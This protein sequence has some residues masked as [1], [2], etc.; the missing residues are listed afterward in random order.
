MDGSKRQGNLL[1]NCLLSV[2]LVG[3]A[4]SIL[5]QDQTISQMVHTVWTGRD[6]A[7]AGI[8]SLAQTPD[9]ILWIA[10]LKGLYS[11]DGLSFA[12][13]EPAPGSASLTA[14]TLRLLFVAKS[15]ELWVAGYHG[16]AIQIHNGRV[17][18]YSRGD[19][20]IDALDYLQQDPSGAMWAVAND[21]Q[22]IRLGA[23]EI[24]HSMPGPIQGQGHISCLFIDSMGTQWVIQNNILY[25]KP[26]RLLQFLPTGVSAHFQPTIREGAHHTVWVMAPT[27]RTKRGDAEPP[28]LQQV[29][30]SGRRLVGPRNVGDLN[31]ILPA[32]DG[33][34]W[35][36][37]QNDELRHLRRWEISEPNSERK[38]HIA[39]VAKLSRGAT[40][41]EFH[42]FMFDADGD[43]WVGGLDGLERFARATLVPAV[44]GAPPGFWHSCVGPSGDIFISRLPAELYRIRNEKLTRIDGVKGGGNLFCSQG[45]IFYLDANGIANL[46]DGKQ[47]HLPLLPG[48][49]GYGDH[50]VFTGVLPMPDGS[51]IGAVG[52][53]PYGTSLWVYKSGKWSRFL[54]NETFPET[55]AMFVDSQGTIYLGHTNGD[56]NRVSGNVFTALHKGSAQFNGVLGFAQTSHG[57]FA[58]GPRG[59]GL[60]RQSSLQLIK[61]RDLDYSKGVTGL[62]EEQNGDV[63]INGFD[64]VVRIPSAEIRAALSDPDYRVSATNLQEQD[65]KGPGLPLLFSSTAHVGPSGRLWFS[66]LNGVVSVD[67]R[68]LGSPHPPLLSIRSITA[69]GSALNAQNEFPPNISILDVRYFALNLSDPR[70]VVYRYRLDGLD[71]GWQDAGHR[72]EAIFTHLRPGK[73]TFYVMAS[74]GDGAWTKTVASAPFT[75]LPSFYQTWWFGALCLV[76]CVALLWIGLTARVR[77]VSRVIRVRA[78]ER[79][80]ERIRIARE[81]HDTLLQGVQ[82]LLLTFHVAAEKVPYGH[83]SKSALEKALTTADRIILEGRNRVTRL[84]AEN[85]TDS[86]LKSLIEGVGADLNGLRAINFAVERRGASDTLHSHVVDEIFCIARE[87]L[88][89]AYRHS[90]ASQIT[91]ELFYQRREF[92]MTCRDNGHG[93]DT[94]AL[95]AGDGNGHWGLRGMAERAEKIGANFSCKSVPE[96][97]TEI[98]VV[99]P[100]WRAYVRSGRLRQIFAR[101]TAA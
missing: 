14:R 2:F 54:P 67:P 48:F 16:G 45:G 3:L 62:V 23:D 32:G 28:R 89:N 21:R 57:I 38:H 35:I 47:S 79:A 8:R 61:F 66:T 30:Q 64:G 7:P 71:S 13:F 78:E 70:S 60:V 94:R 5:A 75:V 83:E 73:Y 87:A 92:R 37:K 63:W 17:T 55:S 69:D 101:R 90:E 72:T 44:P 86:E 34:L 49:R 41:N 10:S 15:G 25:R 19:Q 82:G 81:L 18:E 88:T 51:L 65:F 24:W 58:Y 91:V 77:Y 12:A 43:V 99:V 98:Q 84:R 95:S 80:E 76:T 1:L 4:S 26:Q 29:D 53:S 50:Y 96:N 97:G 42:A 52:G 27:S 46:G 20:P 85:L 40:D 31:D 36:M 59:I 68:H 100:G 33:S 22:L 11:F 93:F 56:I 74:S 6:G 39:D 9:G